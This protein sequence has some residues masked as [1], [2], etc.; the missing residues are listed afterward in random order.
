MRARSSCCTL[1]SHS[2]LAFSSVNYR[3]LT[4]GSFVCALLLFCLFCCCCFKGRE[5]NCVGYS[6]Y[7]FVHL[8]LRSRWR[9]VYFDACVN[10]M[11]VSTCHPLSLSLSLPPSPPPHPT[12]AQSLYVEAHEPSLTSRRLNVFKLCS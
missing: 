10:A 9:A 4:S 12:P 6:S 7:P 1:D 8:S 2:F 3:S 5:G 11:Y